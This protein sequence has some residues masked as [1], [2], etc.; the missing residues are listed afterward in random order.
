MMGA[1]SAVSVVGHHRIIF[2]GL[3]A[4]RVRFAIRV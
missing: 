2:V 4:H 1:V 3:L